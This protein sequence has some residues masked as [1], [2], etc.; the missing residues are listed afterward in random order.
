MSGVAMYQ[1][2]DRVQVTSSQIDLQQPEVLTATVEK[3]SENNDVTIVMDNG[4]R[5]QFHAD[6]VQR[7]GR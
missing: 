6:E 3:V 2:G 7:I 1:E 4:D 5:R